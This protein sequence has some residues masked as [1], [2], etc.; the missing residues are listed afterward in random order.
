MD[1]DNT[2][3]DVIFLRIADQVEDMAR[4]DGILDDESQAAQA[5]GEGTSHR[6]EEEEKEEDERD[7]EL[8]PPK[9]RSAMDQLLEGF[10]AT[11]RALQKTIRERAKEEIIKYRG[12]DGLDVNGDY[13]TIESVTLSYS[14][15]FFLKMAKTALLLHLLP[16]TYEE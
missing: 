9:K 8:E 14:L 2:V 6:E 16:S 3:K 15:R 1:A 13:C 4:A 12:R 11:M 7:D 10:L 5:E